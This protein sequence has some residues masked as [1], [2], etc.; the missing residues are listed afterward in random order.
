MGVE[1]L[2]DDQWVR[3]EP[4][5][6]GGRAGKRGRPSDARRFLDAVLWLAR[7]GARWRDLPQD[8]F[9]PYDTIKRRYY[10][11][12]A[13]GV[14]ERIFAA[15]SA[16]PDLEWISIDATVIRAHPQAAGARRKRGEQKPK[17]TIRRSVAPAAASVPSCTP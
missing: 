15:V 11:W 16:D 12:I 14:F 1:S 3:L 7:T 10:R 4:F 13:A 5:V 9:G 6:P 17:L 2:R 8:R